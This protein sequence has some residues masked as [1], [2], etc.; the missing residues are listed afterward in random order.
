MDN[1]SNNSQSQLKGI[2]PKS[3]KDNWNPIK[4]HNIAEEIVY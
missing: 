3:V 2:I 1:Y 4:D